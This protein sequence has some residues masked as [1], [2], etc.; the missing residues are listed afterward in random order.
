MRNARPCRPADGLFPCGR[1]FVYLCEV[2]RKKSNY[3]ADNRK[4]R[5]RNRDEVGRP[6]TTNQIFRDISADD[7]SKR[8]AD[9]N[10]SV[11]TLALFYGE[12]VSHERPKNCGVEQIENA[13]PDVKRAPSPHLLSR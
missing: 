1:G 5:C 2:V 7:R 11:Q 10:E 8:S 12:K 6:H 9:R 3:K 4:Q 13:D